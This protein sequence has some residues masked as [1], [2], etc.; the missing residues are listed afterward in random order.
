M[1]LNKFSLPDSDR[2]EAAG[3]SKAS[4]LVVAPKQMSSALASVLA[5]YGSAS[6][7]E[8]DGE[9]EGLFPLHKQK[10]GKEQANKYVTQKGK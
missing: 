10:R 5:S 2:E 3:G 4:G 1:L 6:E 7:S 8:S 9:P